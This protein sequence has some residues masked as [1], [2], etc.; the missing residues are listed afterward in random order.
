MGIDQISLQLVLGL[1]C[2][3]ICGV[4][5]AAWAIART[6]R[7][8]ITG[9]IGLA[10]M[11]MAVLIFIAYIQGPRPFLALPAFSLFLL[12]F[13]IIE[14]ANWQFT[15]GEPPIRRVAIVTSAAVGLIVP[16][17]LT[18]IDG[19]GIS[20]VNTLICAILVSA[21]LHCWRCRQEAPILISVLT[22]LYILVALSFL[23]CAVV[24]LIESPIYRVRP[25]NNWAENLN[26]LVSIIGLAG[27]GAI[28]LALNQFRLVQSLKADASTD[29]LTGLNNRRMLF[30]TYGQ[31]PLPTGTALAI[32]DLDHFKSINDRNGHAAGD[33]VIRHFGRLLSMYEEGN[34]TAAR[35]GGEEFVLVVRNTSAS[36]VQEMA[37]RIREAFSQSPTQTEGGLL[38][39]TVSVGVSFAGDSR[40]TLDALM[41]EA[42]KALY[43]AKRN[44]RDRVAAAALP[45]VA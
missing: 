16:F 4:L 11:V 24:I 22:G 31:R 28:S 33:A 14:G 26:A 34:A 6:E 29:L 43:R 2:A 8:L 38:R 36:H 7:F 30:Q 13:A 41:H 35:T 39:C 45:A 15:T 12:G 25:P 3:C 18:G 10:V 19:L 9:A 5:L 40:Y 42:D 32:F 44:G 21:A 27:I 17:F 23:L 1:L 37:D 20:L